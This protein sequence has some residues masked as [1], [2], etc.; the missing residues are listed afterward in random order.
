M[1]GN[2]ELLADGGPTGAWRNVVIDMSAYDGQMATV[3]FLFTTT[4]V[5]ERVGWYLDDIR[6]E[7]TNAVPE[8]AT[9]SIVGLAGLACA[10]RRRRA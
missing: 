6:I 5:V 10:F 1:N 4:A 9:L 8:P 2:L 7:G 3:D